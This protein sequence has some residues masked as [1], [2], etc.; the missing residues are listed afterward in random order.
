[1]TLY[2]R[3]RYYD[4]EGPVDAL[5]LHEVSDKCNGLDGFAQTHFISQDAVEVVVVK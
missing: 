1:M 5:H 3:Q 4:E 2:S